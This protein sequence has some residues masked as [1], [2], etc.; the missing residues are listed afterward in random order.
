MKEMIYPEAYETLKGIVENTEG[1][2]VDLVALSKGRAFAYIPDMEIGGRSY[3]MYGCVRLFLDE[4]GM[5]M[6]DDKNY[7]LEGPVAVEELL[8]ETSLFGLCRFLNRHGIDT[9]FDSEEITERF[10]LGDPSDWECDP[11]SPLDDDEEDSEE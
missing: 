5:L 4:E 1:Q 3:T 8:D 7:D 10:D 6:L 11:D 2:S 9:G